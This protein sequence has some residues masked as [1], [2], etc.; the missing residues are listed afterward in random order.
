MIEISCHSTEMCLRELFMGYQEFV[1]SEE[2]LIGPGAE[3]VE[4]VAEATK[5]QIKSPQIDLSIMSQHQC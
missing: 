2:I 1:T 5:P 4:Q 3:V